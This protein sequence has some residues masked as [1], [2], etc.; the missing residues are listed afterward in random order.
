M[1]TVLI[2]SAATA[3]LQDAFDWYE[4]QQ[5]GLGV[6]FREAVREKLRDIAANPMLYQAAHRDTRRALLDRFPYGLYYR[7]YPGIAIVVACMHGRRSPRIW[8]TRR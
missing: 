1:I 5:T 7:V 8:K 6:E 2:R 4:K 3:D